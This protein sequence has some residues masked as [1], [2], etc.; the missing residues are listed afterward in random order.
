MC[1][2]QPA[3]RHHVLLR[4]HGGGDERSN[5]LDVCRV[6]HDYIHAHPAEAYERGWLRHGGR[7]ELQQDH[8]PDEG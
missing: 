7:D 6:C 3:H 2:D 8:V 4:S 5:T 1:V